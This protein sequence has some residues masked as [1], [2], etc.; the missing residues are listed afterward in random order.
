M[1]VLLPSAA[2]TATTP[3]GV[4]TRHRNAGAGVVLVLDVTA[5]PN[6]AETLTLALQVNDPA[7]NKYVT[8]T[9][10][11]ALTASAL[12]AAPTTET[13]VYS[14][15]PGGLETAATAKHEVQGLAVPEQ[16]RALVTH[17][18]GGS[19]TYSLSASYA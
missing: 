11:T 9:T 17:S 19:W 6:N 15:Y 4:Q 8:I 5:T 10:F 1:P 18:A 2:R 12:G 13:Y 14:V 7:S 3:S 16:W